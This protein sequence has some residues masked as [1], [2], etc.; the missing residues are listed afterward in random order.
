V[1]PRLLELE[2][3]ESLL[4]ESGDEAGTILRAMKQIGIRLS[5][6]DFGTGYSSLAYLK[7]FP[8]DALK[9][10]RS[11]VRDITSNPDDA[12]ITRAVISLAHNLRLKVVAEG[13]ETAAQLGWLVAHGCD[14]MQGFYYSRPLPAGACALFMR[15]AKPL[16]MVMHGRG[17]RT[18]LAVDDEPSILS[19]L[20]RLLSRDGYRILT[21]S[22]ATEAFELLAMNQVDV[23]I[24]DQRMPG[25]SGVEFL[26]RVRGLYPDTVR[27]VMSGHADVQTVTE[28][29]NQ[30]AVYKFCSKPWDNDQLRSDVKDAFAYKLLHD[31]NRKL[32]ERVRALEADGQEGQPQ[33]A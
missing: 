6:D 30:G 3:T 27:I 33:A 21:A 5:V 20:S 1:D 7:S 11:F 32:T 13:V 14:E 24:S 25:T 29:I 17:E 22:G 8:L 4:M 28:A 2:L 19:L 16:Q 12:M 23:V 26:R 10:D 9:I 15:E 31:E 18:L